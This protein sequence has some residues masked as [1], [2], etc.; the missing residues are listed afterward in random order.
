MQQ[1]KASLICLVLGL[2]CLQTQAQFS[3][4]FTDGDFTTGPAT[5]TGD[6]SVFIINGSM[7]LQLNAAMMTAERYLSTPVLSKDST[8]WS[9]YVKCDF[10]PSASNK[11]RI[12]LSSSNPDLT[13][14]LNGYFVQIGGES[15]STDAVEIYRQTGTTTTLV[16]RGVDGHAGTAPELGIEVFRD[17]AGNWELRIDTLGGTAY[18]LEA[19]GTDAVHGLGSYYGVFCDF[20]STRSTLF[21]FDDFTLDPIFV[22]LVPPALDSLIAAYPNT[23]D[24]HFDEA[25]DT[26]I[27]NNETNYSLDGGLGTPVSA[28][29][30]GSDPSLVHLTWTGSFTS[31]TTYHLDISNLE[32]G[33]G[34]AITTITDSFE[35]QLLNYGDLRISEIMA[36]P[37]PVVGLP[38]AEFVELWNLSGADID[39]AGFT[40]SDRS[41]TA[42]IPSVMLPADSFIILCDNADVG[43]FSGMGIVVGISLP[44]LNNSDDSLTLHD[45]YMRLLD[46][47]VYD[48]SW[49]RETSKASGGYTLELIDPMSPC[50]FGANNWAASLDASGGTPGKTNSWFGIVGDTSGPVVDQITITSTTTIQLEFNERLDSASAVD[51]SNYTITPVKYAASSININSPLNTIVT[52]TLSADIDSGV[53][54]KLLTGNIEDCSGNPAGPDFHFF[55]NLYTPDSL[56]IVINE[57]LFNPVSGGVDF[58]EIYNRSTKAINLKGMEISEGLPDDPDSIIDI[59]SITEDLFIV[60]GQYL[61]FSSDPDVTTDDHNCMLPENVIEVSIPNYPDDAG[62]VVLNY[63]GNVVDRLT[64][65]DD[66]HFAL[67]DD[68]DGVTLERISF[69]AATQDEN[70]WHSAASTLGYGTPTYENSQYSEAVEVE[71]ITVY[72]D[73]FSPDGDGYEDLLHIDFNTADVGKVAR[74]LILDVRGREIRTLVNNSLLPLSGGF[75]WDGTT[76]QGEKANIGPYIIYVEW[77]DVKGNTFTYKTKAVLAGDLK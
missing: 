51:L 42:T 12:Y 54:I 25:L 11:A 75:I 58:I 57:V 40:F 14:S 35:I 74:I 32:D 36:D 76:D 66:W 41:S 63:A 61:V 68:L 21:Y 55:G 29:V 77:F 3:D 48:D 39:L 16:C 26:A 20:T 17:D 50:G 1:L 72:P 62:T 34:N 64:Y 45:P 15:G 53:L 52:I 44:S 65:S 56:D 69:D 73:V 2:I 7:Q 22:D 43:L 33:F 46:E 24:L 4:D 13:G 19:S 6:D 31:G 23:L 38:D 27:A 5:W 30:D 60:P 8:T 9:F 10:D 47:V 28:V 49:Y 59:S 67:I 70:N 37:S 18:V 71:S